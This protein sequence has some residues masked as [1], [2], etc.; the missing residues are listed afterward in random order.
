MPIRTE[1]LALAL[2]FKGERDYLHGTDIFNTLVEL[3]GARDNVS[4]RLHCV[5]R[6]G[7]EAVPI[8]D[9]E[10]NLKGFAGLF[11]YGK[12]DRLQKIG[13]RENPTI[14]VTGRVPYDESKVIADASIRRQV[15]ECPGPSRFTF[16]ERVIA[17]NKALLLETVTTPRVRW[18]LTRLD[19]TRV[20]SPAGALRLELVERLGTR[21]TKTSITADGEE[22]GFVYF[23]GT[24]S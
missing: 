8:D 14:E 21:L 9:T 7:V 1:Q 2:K 18:W 4:L 22:V 13:L 15:I 12:A 20:P 24:R 17:L 16:I 23:T 5:M 10:T 11:L 19:L 3:T 6:R